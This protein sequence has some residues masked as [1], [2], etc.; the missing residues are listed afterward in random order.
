VLPVAVERRTAVVAGPGDGW[1]MVSSMDGAVAFRDPAAPM[2]AGWTDYV[3]GVVRELGSVGALTVAARI[4]VASTL[5]IGAGLSSSA[6][7]TVA[8]AAALSGLAGSRLTADELAD[9]AFR[10]EHDQ[11]GVRCGRMDQTIAAHAWPG[12]ALLFET[13]TGELTRTPMPVEF[14]VVETG[15]SHRL[16]GGELNA[17]R[18][19]CEDALARLRRDRPAL[20]HLAELELDDLDDAQNAVGG[21][22]LAKRVRHVVTETARTR[23]AAR[24]LSDGD[25]PALGALL[26][27]GHASLR[28]DYESTIP[29]ADDIVESAVRHGAFG[30]RLTGAG[31][32]GAVVVLVPPDSG[33]EIMAGVTSDFARRYDRAPA[34]WSSHAA[35]GVRFEVVA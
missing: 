7:L 13:A 18:R 16:T 2:G 24:V 25:I 3:S 21:G 15:V 20:R 4:A 33:E 12:T 22:V 29:E 11:V 30:A 34:A 17:R 27:A 1:T 35:G 14:W 5:P 32:G 23:A 28:H 9:V 6:A 26:L 8:A 10:A 19:E 31:W